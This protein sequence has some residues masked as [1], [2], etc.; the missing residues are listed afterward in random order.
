MEGDNLW[1]CD[2]IKVGS[3]HII[4]TPGSDASK[5]SINFN[6][7]PINDHD[8]IVEHDV[9]TV[10]VSLYSHFCNPI[11]KDVKATKRYF[12]SDNPYP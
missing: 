1:F 2:Q 7:D 3:R 4:D 11:R 5:R 10:A 9:E 6:Y 8:L 12:N